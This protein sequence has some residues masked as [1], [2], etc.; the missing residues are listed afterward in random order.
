VPAADLA[1]FITWLKRMEA[2]VARVERML[3]GQG[4]PSGALDPKGLVYP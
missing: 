4:V 1:P 3:A 2:E